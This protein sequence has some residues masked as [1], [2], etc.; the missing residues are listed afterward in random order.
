MKRI[1]QNNLLD[2]I[3]ESDTIQR[4]LSLLSDIFNS[5]DEVKYFLTILG[6]NIL[7]KNTN[8]IHIMDYNIKEFIDNIN[9]Y[10]Q[11]IIGC[12]CTNTI[13]YKFYD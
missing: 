12:N 1:K 8:L 10:C 3:P 9:Q 2:S 13:K 4:I 6:D 7:K 11:A 5:K